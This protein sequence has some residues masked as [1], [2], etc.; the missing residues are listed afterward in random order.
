[1]TRDDKKDMRI[2]L[3]KMFVFQ[4]IFY[5]L[6]YLVAYLDSGV[7]TNDGKLVWKPMVISFYS[8]SLILTFVIPMIK[9]HRK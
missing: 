7:L 2:F 4:T 6:F 5:S 1:M 8:L 3:F 9:I